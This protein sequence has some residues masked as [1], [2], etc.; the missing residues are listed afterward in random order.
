MV[1]RFGSNVP[2]IQAFFRGSP[3]QS[4][5]RTTSS[6]TFE[7]RPATQKIKFKAPRPGVAKPNPVAS[8]PGAKKKDDD[9]SLVDVAPD[10]ADPAGK[11]PWYGLTAGERNSLRAFL[12][13]GITGAG[14][15]APSHG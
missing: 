14:S 1:E 13:N 8:L 6:I 10:T 4:A 3:R 15:P 5:V 12:K 9:S 11:V 2:E 7:Y